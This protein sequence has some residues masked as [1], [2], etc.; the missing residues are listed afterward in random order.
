[1][2]KSLLPPLVR[3][4]RGLFVPKQDLLEACHYPFRLL[5]DQEKVVWV[6]RDAETLGRQALVLGVETYPEILASPNLAYTRKEFLGFNVCYSLDAEPNTLS[7][8]EDN[9][10]LLALL[11]WSTT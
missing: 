11:R 3:E 7:L 4:R 2:V 8:C 9:G 6:V 1:M 5:I 10:D